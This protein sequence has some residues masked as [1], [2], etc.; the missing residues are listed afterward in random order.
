[1]Q[2]QLNKNQIYAKIILKLHKI[3]SIYEGKILCEEITN[4]IENDIKNFYQQLKLKYKSSLNIKY[5]NELIK[6]PIHYKIRY[7]TLINIQIDID[8][9][10]LFK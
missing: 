1:M 9:K 2:R 4:K 3:L 7:H 10:R 6:Q 8:L 5:L